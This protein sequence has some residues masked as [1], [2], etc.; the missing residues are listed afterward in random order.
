MEKSFDFQFLLKDS[1]NPFLSWL[2]FHAYLK[3]ILS[4]SLLNIM[5][6]RLIL[7]I[8]FHNLLSSSF[9]N[10]VEIDFNSSLGDRFGEFGTREFHNVARYE[11]F[12]NTYLYTLL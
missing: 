1:I 4:H 6:K 5:S 3:H 10:D 9:L 12:S 11:L 7:K 2:L 8:K